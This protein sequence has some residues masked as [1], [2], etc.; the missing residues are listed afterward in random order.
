[1]SKESIN[2]QLRDLKKDPDALDQ[3]IG[4]NRIL[5]TLIDGQKKTQ[6]W[7]CILLVVSLLCNVAICTIFVAYE[8]QFATTTETITIT[9]DT[10]EGE[11]NN[12]YQSGSDAQYIQGDSSGEVTTDGTTD[13]NYYSENQIPN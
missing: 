2:D 12:V 4:L 13:D 8:S 1:M 10:G 11:G 6:K 7:L 5:L 3:S 9:Q